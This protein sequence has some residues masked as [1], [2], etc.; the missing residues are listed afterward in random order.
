ME[1]RAM[2]KA[3]ETGSGSN[4]KAHLDLSV[5]AGAFVAEAVALCISQ[6]K[7]RDKSELEKLLK[8]GDH[9]AHLCFRRSLGQRISA[10]LGEIGGGINRVYYVESLDEPVFQGMLNLIAIVERKTEALN[11]LKD[12]LNASLVEEYKQITGNETRNLKH[13]LNLVFMDAQE[14]EDKVGEGAILAS[15]FNPP[16]KIWD[17]AG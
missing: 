13:L 11:S 6:L 1:D 14:V 9:E 4:P 2:A 12:G 5:L 7:L 17:K 3:S 16:E 10:Y 15:R 8:T